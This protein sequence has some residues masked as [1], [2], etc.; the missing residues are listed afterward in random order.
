MWFDL[1]VWVIIIVFKFLNDIIYFC[2]NI[3]NYIIDVV[4]WEIFVMFILFVKILNVCVYVFDRIMK[5]NI[6]NNNMIVKFMKIKNNIFGF[7]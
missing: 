6:R 5:L 3:R 2:F 4:L 1:Y 7:V